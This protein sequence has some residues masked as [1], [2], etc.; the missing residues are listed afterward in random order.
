MAHSEPIH[1]YIAEADSIYR[2]E[3]GIMV[4]GFDDQ[5]AAAWLWRV[6]LQGA[7]EGNPPGSYKCYGGVTSIS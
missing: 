1:A 7:K 2:L 4:A 6:T 3:V 5:L